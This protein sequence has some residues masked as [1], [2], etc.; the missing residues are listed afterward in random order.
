MR[1]VPIQKQKWALRTY[2]QLV[3]LFGEVLVK[4]P[5][6]RSASVRALFQIKTFLP[7]LVHTLHAWGSRWERSAVCCCCL[8]CCPYHYG[9]EISGTVS[10]DKLL[11]Y[12]LL[13][14]YALS[15]HHKSDHVNKR[16]LSSILRTHIKSQASWCIFY[17]LCAYGGKD[18]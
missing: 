8:L 7:F 2:P 11:F 4:Q 5:C 18:R 16:T 17:S 10:P 9:F 12:K 15:Q 1:S 6:W 13:W 14:S 3:V